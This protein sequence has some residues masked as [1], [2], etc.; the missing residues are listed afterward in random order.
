MQPPNFYVPTPP[1]PPGLLWW[2][3]ADGVP[4][5]PPLGPEFAG[6]GVKYDPSWRP[7]NYVPNNMDTVFSILKFLWIYKQVFYV[8]HLL[9]GVSCLIYIFQAA[10]WIFMFVAADHVERREQ[11]QS[12]MDPLPHDIH[13]HLRRVQ[14]KPCATEVV[15]NASTSRP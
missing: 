14:C 11:I 3:Y 4:P 13:C 5:I 10:D 1:A 6:Y 2:N 8:L 12:S 7:K 9:P 15:M